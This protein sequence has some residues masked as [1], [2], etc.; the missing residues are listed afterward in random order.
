[1]RRLPIALLAV[2]AL[3]VAGC[4]DDEGGAG[5]APVV[6]A[7]ASPTQGA[8]PLE[9]AF[10]VDARYADGESAAF[11]YRWD[12]GDG[13]T[14]TA[15][16]PTHTYAEEGTYQ[17]SVRVTDDADGAAAADQ[18]TIEV[19]AGTEGA[20]DEGSDE[21]DE[22]DDDTTTSKPGDGDGLVMFDDWV[23]DVNAAC[24]ATV[25]AGEAI[26]PAEGTATLTD[27]QWAQFA[28]LQRDELDAVEAAGVPDTRTDEAREWLALHTEGGTTFIEIVDDPPVEA[29]DPGWAD[30]DEIGADLAER[31]RALGLT[32]CIGE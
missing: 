20:D 2:V 1:M 32:S 8:A 6:E 15:A 13:E 4:T 5:V 27:E 11:A 16:A 25:T 23:D 31:S 26:Q 28:D 14:S 10:E 29:T 3:A 9:V 12:F 22:S 17:V 7:T 21:S 18:L 24:D 30:L 19:G